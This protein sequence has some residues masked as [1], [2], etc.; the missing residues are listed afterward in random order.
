MSLFVRLAAAASWLRSLV[1][2]AIV[3][4]VFFFSSFSSAALRF[5]RRAATLSESA[6]VFS[7]ELG[8][9]GC[10]RE[11]GG[12]CADRLTCTGERKLE[13][14]KWEWPAHCRPRWRRFLDALSK[15]DRVW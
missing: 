1:S 3:S 4:A 9:L 2:W 8:C 10:A 7:L 5:L 11:T 12:D 13:V 15:E 14:A 6:F